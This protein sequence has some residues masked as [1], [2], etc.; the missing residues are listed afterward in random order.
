LRFT[1]GGDRK[2]L[3]KIDSRAVQEIQPEL[4]SDEIILWA[5]MPNPK[6]IF[7]S[8]DWAIIPFAAMWLGFSIFWE[9]DALGLTS[10]NPSRH[11]DLFAVLWGIPFFLFGNY[12][13]WIR[14]VWDAWAKRRTYYAITN[15]RVVLL[16]RAWTKR[17]ASLFLREVP[18]IE[19]EGRSTGTLWLGPK[20]PIFGG[21][22]QKLRS[23]SRFDFGDVPVLADI[24]TAYS[25]HH[26]LL[27]LC[28]KNESSRGYTG[29]LS[30]RG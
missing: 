21:R 24:D 7:H 2:Q 26:L 11:A 28:A 1:P 19:I 29:P 12:I 4:L 9:A 14:F 10:G 25:V 6:I 15:R 3:I 17:I 27:D 8:D 5:D 30:Y 13:F 18:S 16:Q 22:G 20:Y 23:M